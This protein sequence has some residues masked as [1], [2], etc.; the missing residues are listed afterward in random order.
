[1]IILYNKVPPEL[2]GL[3]YSSVADTAKK[4][5]F[6]VHRNV[7][8][9]FIESIIGSSQ[10]IAFEKEGV[11][12]GY[13]MFVENEDNI[14]IHSIFVKSIFR[15]AKIGTYL[16]NYIKNYNKVIRYSVKTRLLDRFLKENVDVS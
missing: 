4:Y 8:R 5:I 2:K 12:M 1:M 3:I 10:L 13:C 7:L 9:A 15:K 6:Q 11:V 14:I 16:L